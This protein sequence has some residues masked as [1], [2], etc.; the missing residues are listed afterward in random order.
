[1]LIVNYAIDL[2]PVQRAA[3]FYQDEVK[4][5]LEDNG[6]TAINSVALFDLCQFALNNQISK[7]HVRQ[8]VSNGQPI[9]NV[10]NLDEVITATGDEPFKT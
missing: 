3:R 4:G 7:E 8:F 9:I 6:I 2:D 10:V 5:R 1:L